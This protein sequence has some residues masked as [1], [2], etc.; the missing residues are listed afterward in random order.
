[1][2]GRPYRPMWPRSGRV[3]ISSSSASE[4]CPAG[5][6]GRALLRALLDGLGHDRLLLMAT[7][8]AT[9]PARRLYAAE[10]WVVLGPGIGDGTVIM[11]KR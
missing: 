5:G 1:M 4:C 3:G 11:G 2:R 7:A 6:V 9:D 10:G 8:D